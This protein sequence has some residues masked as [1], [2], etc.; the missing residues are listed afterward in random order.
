MNFVS[1]V[2]KRLDEWVSED[3]L[4]TRQVYFPKKIQ[5]SRPSSPVVN[6]DVILS[7]PP[8]TTPTSIN[9]K[10]KNNK[11]PIEEVDKVGIVSSNTD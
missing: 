3:R 5:P 2:N 8:L 7:I 6:N 10:K 9:K 1:I 11:R 4:D